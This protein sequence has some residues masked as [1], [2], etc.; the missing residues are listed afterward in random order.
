MKGPAVE[1][2]GETGCTINLSLVSHTNVGK[3]TLVRTLLQQ[4]VGEVRDAAHVT[5]VSTGYPLLQGGTDTL[6]L[7]DTPGFGDTARLVSRLRK[8]G[9]PIGWLLTQV[10]DR[11]RERPLWSSQ[12]AV[13]NAREE[14]DVI[15]YLVNASEDPAGAAYIPLEMEV[16]EWVGKPIVLLLNQTGPPDSNGADDEERWSSQLASNPLVRNALTLDAFARCWVQEET[17]LRAVAPLLEADKQRAFSRL[18]E[19]WKARN[20]ERFGAAMRVLAAPLAEAAR[21]REEIGQDKW[22]DRVRGVVLN[23]AGGNHSAA[24]E[25]A[26]GKLAE[27][28]TEGIRKST[29]ELIVLHGLSGRALQEVLRRVE[30]DYT[31]SAPA[32]PGIAAVLGG[33][34]S[35]AAGGLAADVAA[36]GLTLGGGMIIGGIL[37]AVGAGSAAK[38]YNL[39]RGEDTN[40]V[41]WSEQFYRELMHA[42]LLRYLA[43]AH[44]GRGR[45]DWEEGE[46]PQRWVAAVAD[47]VKREE[48][49]ISRVW[50]RARDAQPGDLERRLEQLLIR[51]ACRLLLRLYPQA[52]ELLEHLGASG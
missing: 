51:M 12:Q 18:V 23:P 9:N 33:L 21:D 27:R 38:T 44:F 26:M 49:A 15:L 3:T 10:W 45:G 11:F 47:E 19:V 2:S 52:T 4:D 32:R 8:T 43:V 6:M 31:E 37:G 35:G 14:A 13:R 50:N 24:G 22:H 16:L 36:G 7:W 28:L 39:A 42:A 40:V 25:R 20:L 41:R 29:N 17:L 1:G 48:Q 30:R 5:E 46:H 34:V